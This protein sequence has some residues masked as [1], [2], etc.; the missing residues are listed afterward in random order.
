MR[1]CSLN[2]CGRKH[3]GK[4]YC[5]AHYNRLRRSGTVA[6]DIPVVDRGINGPEC[7][8]VDCDHQPHAH[9][10]C[11]GHWSRVRNGGELRPGEPLKGRRTGCDAPAC[12]RNHSAYGYCRLHSH[13]MR[14][15]GSLDIPERIYEECAVTT[16]VRLVRSNGYCNG[17]AERL[18]LNGTVDDDR[19]LREFR[20][21]CELDGCARTHYSLGFCV[22]HYQQRI[23]KPRRRALETTAHGEVTAEKLQARIDYYG[24]QC[25][26]CRAPWTCIDH[27]K[28]LAQGG[29]NWPANLRPACTPCNASKHN[30][31]PYKPTKIKLREAV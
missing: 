19:P 17:H 14:K 9:G 8:V 27:V 29:S 3:W 16:C 22:Q 25:W 10:M 11:I 24:R 30:R 26:M 7:I 6:A 12:N 13:R 5:Q 21:E 31:W 18:R 2:G 1:T 28:P 4:G 20:T 15:Y 23:S